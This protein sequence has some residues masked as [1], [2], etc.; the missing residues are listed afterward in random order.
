M[1]DPMDDTL[2]AAVAVFA[3]KT[4]RAR[5]EV[6]RAELRRCSMELG[7]TQAALCQ[8]MQH[9]G[10]PPPDAFYCLDI[11]AIRRWL[12]T[13]P[14]EFDPLTT[15]RLMVAHLPKRDLIRLLRGELLPFNSEQL[16]AGTVIHCVWVN[17]P[18]ECIS[19]VLAHESFEPVPA[20]CYWPAMQLQFELPPQPADTPA[21]DEAPA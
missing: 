17:G 10:F 13:N 7:I 5:E 4:R 3:E 8:W 16:P 18:P 15:D 20:N 6:C 2:R 11:D 14:M 21:A 19:L 1:T 9:P 12:A